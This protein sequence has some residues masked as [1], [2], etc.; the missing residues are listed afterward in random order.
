MV[1]SMLCIFYHNK[2]LFEGIINIR[3]KDFIDLFK[4]PDLGFID[5][6]YCCFGFHFVFSNHCYFVTC[7]T[8]YQ[9]KKN[10]I[11][12]LKYALISSSGVEKWGQ[13]EPKWSGQL[14]F[15]SHLQ[16]LD[17]CDGIQQTSATGCPTWPTALFC[18]EDGVSMSGYYRVS[19][20]DDENILEMDNGEG[21]TT[22]QMYL[23]PLNCT[24]KNAKMVGCLGGLVS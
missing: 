1:S 12:Y 21:C 15:P 13:W 18:W 24:V 20:W 16:N 2:K 23:I 3:N 17:A 22:M 10:V 8:V 11:T 4:E 6:F 19:S 14:T 5:L 9:D 7:C